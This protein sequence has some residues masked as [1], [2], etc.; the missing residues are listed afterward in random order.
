MLKVADGAAEGSQETEA[1]VEDSKGT[2]NTQLLFCLL[3]KKDISSSLFTGN[4]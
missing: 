2:S 1:G 4:L 3:E